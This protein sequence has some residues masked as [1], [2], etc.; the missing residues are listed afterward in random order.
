MF[1]EGF[2][3]RGCVNYF[4][5]LHYSDRCL[6]YYIF[7]NSEFPT[8]SLLCHTL[9][10]ILSNSLENIRKL[11]RLNKANDELNRLYVID[12][13]CNI[14]NRNG[15]YNRA[16]DIFKECAADNRQIMISFID[17]DGLKFINDNYGHNEGDFA[18]QRLASTI[19]TC[20]GKSGICARFGGDEFVYFN[21]NASKNDAAIF[22]KKINKSLD[23]LNKLVQKPYT[24]SASIGSV[25]TVVEKDDTLFSIIKM[26]YINMYEVKKAK[27][28][29]LKSEKV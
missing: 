10:M 1:P 12:P 4:L 19:S 21:P 27:K 23:E 29:A 14:Y 20:C 13:L 26:A 3:E 7:T 25:I 16:D 8:Y 6:G 11:F 22:A 15:F 5:P 28:S 18:I 24:I 17:M 9:T 2:E